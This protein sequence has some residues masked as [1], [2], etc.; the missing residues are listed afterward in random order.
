MMESLKRDTARLQ[1]EAAETAVKTAAEM[2]K[3]VPA[4]ADF[5]ADHGCAIRKIATFADFDAL[6]TMDKHSYVMPYDLQ[7]RC[8]DGTLSGKHHVFS[9]SGSS[10]EP[11]YWAIAPDDE[12]MMPEMYNRILE[13]SLDYRRHSCLIIVCLG[14]GAWISGLQTH[15]AL[16]QAG[17]ENGGAFTLVTPGLDFE[18]TM[19][20][21]RNLGPYFDTIFLISYP[22]LARIIVEHGLRQGIDWQKFRMRL[23]LVGD[24]FSESWR[25][26]MVELLGIDKDEPLPVFG[27]YGGADMGGV[28]IESPLSVCIRKQAE[29]NPE[30]KQ[31]LFHDDRMPFLCRSDPRS[32]FTEVQDGEL[33]FTK[34][35]AVPL[36]RYR[37]RDQG[38]MIDYAEMLT[39]LRDFGISELP[40][41]QEER[42]YPEPLPFL[43]IFG[44]AA[45]NLTLSGANVYVGH[46]RE[47]LSRSQWNDIL[48]GRFVLHKSYNQDFQECFHIDIELVPGAAEPDAEKLKEWSENIQRELCNICSEYATLCD[49]ENN[50]KQLRPVLKVLPFNHRRFD[51][52]TY[53][54]VYV[55]KNE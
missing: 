12:K 49:I 54:S 53:K 52:G 2:L 42:L 29:A 19:S 11:Q 15:W 18:A 8:L 5:L 4:Y 32:I 33:L 6:P 46:I 37:I 27:G 34:L 9:S 16:R 31:Q 41:E 26:Y 40:L 24:N 14:L 7:R 45:G 10:G 35:K 1:T 50:R 47:I 25:N 20:F 23:G 36:A 39:V 43:Y 30:L 51:T 13:V 28:G 21:V 38:G 55:D 22:G 3:R 44:K 17:I 48:T